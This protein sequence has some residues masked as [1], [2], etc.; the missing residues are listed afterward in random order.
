K[1]TGS[2]EPRSRRTDWQRLVS[3][4]WSMTERATGRLVPSA[5]WS[6]PGNWLNPVPSSRS[7]ETLN[8]WPETVNCGR[9]APASTPIIRAPTAAAAGTTA[10]V[11]RR[12]LV[13]PSTRLPSGFLTDSSLPGVYGPSPD[14]RRGRI[15]GTAPGVPPGEMML[16]RGDP[17]HKTS[18]YSAVARLHRP[19]ITESD[20]QQRRW[21]KYTGRPVQSDGRI[22]ATRDAP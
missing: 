3:S 11:N 10:R 9:N 8:C 2:R 14:G 4:A 15:R 13:R 7:A 5:V 6:K 19:L 21:W 1:R 18:C 22:P 17:S 16:A 12:H 20:V